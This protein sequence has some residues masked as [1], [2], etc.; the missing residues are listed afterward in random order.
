MRVAMS[1][2]VTRDEGQNGCGSTPRVG[3]SSPLALSFHANITE[4][5]KRILLKSRTA[6]QKGFQQS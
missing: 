3:M 4:A 2:H 5:R 1:L 6:R